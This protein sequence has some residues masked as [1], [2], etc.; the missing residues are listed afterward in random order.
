MPLKRSRKLPVSRRS[1][2]PVVSTSK[3]A[4]I[5]YE[6]LQE[7][8]WK[9]GLTAGE[10]ISE[11]RLAGEL[12]MSRTPVREAIRRMETEGVVTQVASSGTYV[13]APERSEIVEAYEVRMA[14]ENFAVRKA[15]RRMRP[16]QVLELQKLCDEM[17]TAI[18]KFR[19]SKAPIMT[20]ETLQQYLNAD[21]GFHF[22]LL[23]A[24][25]N[26]RALTIFGDVNLRSAIFGCRSHERDLHHV[27][28]VWLQHARVAR[29]LRQRDPDAAQRSLEA[30][31]QASMNGALEAYD[32]R[33]GKRLEP[34]THPPDLTQAMTAL[35]T[36]LRGQAR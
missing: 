28:W 2:K 25:E 29:A 16:A 23:K 4:Q 9:G 20:G 1:K 6:H 11:T 32:A 18:R 13:T 21:L 8:L 26:R 10:K 36:E 24:A 5:A 17:R 14:I 15:T 31:M 33:R 34:V 3:L 7:Q 12:G 19:K 30:H 22:L 27:A 35:I